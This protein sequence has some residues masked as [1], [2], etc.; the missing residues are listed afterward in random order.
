MKDVKDRRT[1]RKTKDRKRRD[2]RLDKLYFS[3]LSKK[4][5][6]ATMG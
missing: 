6:V 1:D 4:Q 5:E 2:I 3:Q